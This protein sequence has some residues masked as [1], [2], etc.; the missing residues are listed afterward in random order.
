MA[1]E[2]GRKMGQKNKGGMRMRWWWSK[3]DGSE[4]QRK[5]IL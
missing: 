4:A 2:G 5:S 1:D 3:G